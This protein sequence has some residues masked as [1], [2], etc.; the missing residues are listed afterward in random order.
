LKSGDIDR[1][2]LGHIVFSDDSARN[3]LNAIVHPRVLEK[4]IAGIDA[5]KKRHS[6]RG[7]V[8]IFDVPLLIETGM[9]DLVDVVVLVDLPA[10]IQKKRLENRDGLTDREIED[11]LSS[12]MSAEK[13]KQYVD[14]T[15]NNGG[16]LDKTRAQVEEFWDIIP[17]LL[18]K[19]RESNM[20][21]KNNGPGKSG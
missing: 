9:H 21:T 7:E 13:K 1:E 14:F 11:R 16:G 3:K 18:D 2:K 5:L 10:D 19:K 12:Q 17:V 6:A 4:M 20:E 15:I 8:I